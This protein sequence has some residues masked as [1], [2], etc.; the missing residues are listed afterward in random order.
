[1]YDMSRLQIDKCTKQFT[2]KI[3][4]CLDEKLPKLSK[5]AKRRMLERMMVEMARIVHNELDFDPSL[6]LSSD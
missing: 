4:A 6:I 5:L 3:P 2:F 1:M